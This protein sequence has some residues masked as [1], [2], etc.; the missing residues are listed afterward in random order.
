MIWEVAGEDCN[1]ILMFEL[2]KVKDSG[3]GVSIPARIGIIAF[4]ANLIIYID[5]V[6][7]AG[8]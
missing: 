7:E 1:C 8:W 4:P 2:D 6:G 3:V 5:F